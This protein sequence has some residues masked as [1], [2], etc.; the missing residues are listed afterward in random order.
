MVLVV[1][2]IGY[3]KTEVLKQINESLLTIIER[4]EEDKEV[5]TLIICESS[6]K[7]KRLINLF[8][9]LLVISICNVQV[10]KVLPQVRQY[11][12]LELE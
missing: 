3:A 10:Y 5:D 12:Q 4:S 2:I 11:N 7:I 1:T 6:K 9:F 8:V